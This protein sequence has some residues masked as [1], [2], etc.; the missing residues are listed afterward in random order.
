MKITAKELKQKTASEL[1]MMLAESREKIRGLRFDLASKKLKN[2][3]ESQ[4]VKR[5]IARILTILKGL[6]QHST[7]SGE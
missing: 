1:K 7:P 4:L 2:T 3:K 5:Q 6:A